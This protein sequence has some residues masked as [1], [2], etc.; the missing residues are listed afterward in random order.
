M[1]EQFGYRAEAVQEIM[2]IHAIA[3]A[4]AN[5]SLHLTAK[6]TKFAHRC[7]P[8]I[9]A[10]ESVLFKREDSSSLLAKIRFRPVNE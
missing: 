2:F 3:P 1:A 6:Q 10:F 7:H 5:N 4:R 8:A 9:S